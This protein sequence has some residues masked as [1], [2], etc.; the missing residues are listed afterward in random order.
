MVHF[1]YY[2]LHTNHIILRAYPFFYIC[3]SLDVADPRIKTLYK[4]A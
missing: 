3:S 2:I 1:N 4:E